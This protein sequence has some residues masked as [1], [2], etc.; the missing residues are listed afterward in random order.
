MSKVK[1]FVCK[2]MGHYV[3]QCPNRK[4][5]SGGTATT[6]EE[7]EFQTLFER[8]CVFL[9]C[10]TSVETAPRIWYIDNGASSHMTR[11]REHLTDL[12]DTEVR[13]EIALE[14]DSLVKVVDIGIFIFQ[15]DSMPPISFMDVLYVPGLRKN[16]ISISTLQDRDLEVSFRG[17]EVF[18]HPK[19]S[20]L[21]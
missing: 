8:E 9:I 13:M 7:A 15:R 19:G 18:I 20:S 14:N 4:K 12:R 2:K 6:A 3:G 11:V 1:C 21:T 16:L 17:T 5:K 10:L